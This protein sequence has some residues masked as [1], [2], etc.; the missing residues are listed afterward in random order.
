MSAFLLAAAGLAAFTMSVYVFVHDTLPIMREEHRFRQESRLKWGGYK[1]PWWMGWAW[2]FGV[3]KVFF[4]SKIHE[5][6]RMA[7]YLRR[8]F[9]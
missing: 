8:E 1:P 9:D 5:E 6:E 4:G 7:A 3:E 2:W